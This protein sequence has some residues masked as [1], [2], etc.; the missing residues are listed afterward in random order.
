MIREWMFCVCP[1]MKTLNGNIPAPLHAICDI[2]FTKLGF[3]FSFSHIKLSSPNL[4][5]VIILGCVLIY[6][7]VYMIAIDG[8][9]VDSSTLTGLCRVSLSE[10]IFSYT[11]V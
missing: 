8:K 4:N 10:Q 1:I 11:Q 3:R 9:L 6:I 2:F 5:N 7:S